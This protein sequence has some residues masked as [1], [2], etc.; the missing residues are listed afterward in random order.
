MKMDENGKPEY[1]YHPLV[2]STVTYS[3]NTTSVDP[4]KLR[5]AMKAMQEAMQKKLDEQLGY[6]AQT[7]PK[8]VSP[9]YMRY[10]LEGMLFDR[11]KYVVHIDDLAEW[12]RMLRKAGFSLHR[13]PGKSIIHFKHRDGGTVSEILV[14]VNRFMPRGAAIRMDMDEINKN[15]RKNLWAGWRDLR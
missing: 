2:T 1:P 10:L 6:K 11:Y 7:P 12:W 3:T 4:E 15:I 14:D 5:E 9:G 8:S 13:V